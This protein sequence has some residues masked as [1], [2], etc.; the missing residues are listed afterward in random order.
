MEASLESTNPG[1]AHGLTTTM[2]VL[3]P[4][5]SGGGTWS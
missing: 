5:P 1:R 3:I 2:G 4:S